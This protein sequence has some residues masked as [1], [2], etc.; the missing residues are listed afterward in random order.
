MIEKKNAFRLEYQKAKI[1]YYGNAV[2]RRLL[3]KN[4]SEPKFQRAVLS[5]ED[6]N[7]KLYE[8]VCAGKPFAAARFGGTETKT[9]ADVLYTQAGGKLGG[10]NDRTLERIMNLS[11]FFP[12]DQQA[13]YEFTRIY[14]ECCP[15]IDVLGVWNILLQS[16]LADHCVTNATLAE[17]RMFEP[18]YFE[19]PWTAS[20]A[21]KRV[22]VVHPF[23]QTIESQYRKREQLF[24]NQN[25]LPQFELRTVKAVQT[26]AGETDERFSTW[27]E[28][29]DYMY[30]ECMKEDFD[31][32][33]IGCGAYG[34]PLAA[35]LKNAGKQAVHV[36]GSLQLLFGIKGSRWDNHE[37]ISKLYN[38]AWVR[39]SANEAIKKADK[40]EGSCYW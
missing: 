12:A 24:E 33:L 29:L 26:L 5:A 9:I 21:G 37:V 34:F 39:P 3:G 31:I 25:I 10:L 4:I 11:G 40:V 35:R 38:D 14:M 7:Q 13:L 18:Y 6:G 15:D 2:A 22:V 20:L 30:E 1:S 23:S 27:F 32:A 16:Y 8:L 28:A 19:K 17:L 36:G